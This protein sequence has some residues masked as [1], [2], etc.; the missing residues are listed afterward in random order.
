MTLIDLRLSTVLLI[1]VHLVTAP[2]PS[3]FPVCFRNDPDI[4]DCI[5][6]SVTVLQ[7]RLITGDLGDGYLIPTADPFHIPKLSFGTERDFKTT[8]M[9]LQ[10]KGMS[11]FSIVKLKADINNLKF[12][13]ILSFPHLNLSSNYQMIFGLFGSPLYSNGQMFEKLENTRI[14]LRMKAKL[15]TKN[16]DQYMRFD[17]FYFK[18]LQSDVKSLR[19][20]K[21]FPNTLFIGPTIYSY[22]S[23]NKEFVT[24]AIYP[25]FE[26]TLSSAFTRMANELA[27]SATFDELFPL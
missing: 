25:D 23:D 17:P 7:P 4:S 6:Q 26:R 8:L 12:S 5:I 11:N 22:F 24:R 2:L 14:G 9:N 3:I 15:Y 10:I 19:F 13:M 1:A 18:I 20:T 27:T 16:N 21:L